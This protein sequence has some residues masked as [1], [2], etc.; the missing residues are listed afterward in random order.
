MLT[1][2]VYVIVNW[3]VLV[4]ELRK[5]NLRK[6]FREIFKNK[7]QIIIH[8]GVLP[9]LD[10]E[11]D[12][13]EM[14]EFHKLYNEGVELGFII[15]NLEICSLK[16]FFKKLYQTLPFIVQNLSNDDRFIIALH[17][18]LGGQVK[19]KNPLIHRAINWIKLEPNEWKE[20][21]LKNNHL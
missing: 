5:E 8:Y 1:I 15:E 18:Q 17:I 4:D 20:H 6:F 19:T 11:L 14:I 12:I 10:A 9:K 3:D 21:A 16:P 2:G 13:D 7:N